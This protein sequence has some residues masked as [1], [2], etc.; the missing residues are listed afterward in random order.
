MATSPLLSLIEIVEGGAR[1][2]EVDLGENTKAKKLKLS[3]I[4]N[5]KRKEE[6][7]RQ[8]KRNDGKSKITFWVFVVRSRVSYGA[9]R[10][11]ETELVSAISRKSVCGWKNNLLA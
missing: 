7:I 5:V 6:E 11:E 10:I 3:Q 1:A 2:D 4:Q 8:T 9:I